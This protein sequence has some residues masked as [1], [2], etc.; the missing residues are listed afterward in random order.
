MIEFFVQKERKRTGFKVLFSDRVK[1][2]K[3]TDVIIPVYRPT[4]QLFELLDKLM[5]QTVPVNKILLV[6]TE[7]KY[8]DGLIIGMDFWHRYKNVEVKHISKREFDHGDTRRRAVKETESPYFV[9]MTDDAIPADNRMLERLLTPLWEKKAAMSYARQLP[10][11]DCGVIE[12]YTRSFNYPEESTYK[13]KD[14]LSR[15]G[16][17][18]FFASNVCAAYDRRVYDSLGGFVKKTIFNEDM[19][20]ARKMIDAGETIA[21]VADARVIHSHN[22]SGAAQFRRNFD[23]GVSHAQFP[24]IFE[25]MKTEGEGIRLVTR[26]A[27]YLCR[28][29]KPWLVIKLFWQSFCKYAGYFLGKRYQKL[30]WQMVIGCSMNKEYWK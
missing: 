14:D 3:Q 12:Q 21:Y 18:T 22:Y 29:K 23:L 11:P 24:Q 8:F 4:S 10:G 6:N 30:P 5:E 15:L 17:K 20:L 2:M 9:M 28:I 13:N 25:G 27:G 16:I 7:Q 1:N 26:T 19:I